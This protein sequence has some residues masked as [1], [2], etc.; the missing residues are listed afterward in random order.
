M[1]IIYTDKL[2][3]IAR[4]S[5]PP[6]AKWFLSLPGRL[7]AP[8]DWGIYVVILQKG[9]SRPPYSPCYCLDYAASKRSD[10]RREINWKQRGGEQRERK[11]ED[12]G[13]FLAI[14]IC[15][16]PTILTLPGT[17]RLSRTTAD[18][19]ADH[20]ATKPRIETSCTGTKDLA[21]TSARFKKCFRILTS[22]QT[23]AAFALLPSRLRCLEE[24]RYRKRNQL[25]TEGER[26]EYTDKFLQISNKS[27]LPSAN[28]FLSL[29]VRLPTPK[30]R[31]QA[32][33]L[34][35]DRQR[36]NAGTEA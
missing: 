15:I 22:L 14:Y 17:S 19:S 3:E 23:G 28:W 29:P 4:K 32:P 10:I 33:V 36:L 18:Y 24:E 26:G 5:S 12:Q 34:N 1:K 11:R 7:P 30:A 20:T 21:D 2:L 31:I 35:S 9:S 25:E 6:S 13:M 8:K 27:A 16:L